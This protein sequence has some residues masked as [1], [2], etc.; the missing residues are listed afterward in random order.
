MP[1]SKLSVRDE[2]K[3]FVLLAAILV[4][5]AVNRLL[6]G[7]LAHLSWIANIG[8]FAVMYTVMAFVEISDVAVAFRKVK[9]TVLALVT[10]FV[11]TPLFAWV[12]GWLVLRPYPDLWAGVILYT[13]TPC[14]GWYLIFTDLAHG[15]VPWGVSLLPWN[16]VLQILLLPLYLWL[17]VGKVVPTSAGTLFASVALYLLA[18]FALGYVVRETLVKTRGR[19]WAYGAYK[20]FIGEVKMWALALL[21]VAIFAFQ[22][23]FGN[24]ALARIGLIIAVISL[25][26]V[27]LFILSL[28]VG[29]LFHLGYADT[30]TLVFTTTARNSESV[31]GVAAVAFAGHPLVL[32]AILIGPVIELPALLG[33]TRLMLWLRTRL[34]WP[35]PDEDAASLR[36]S[37]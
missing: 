35:E 11:F 31:I 5:I 14:I 15:D 21:V 17:L 13:L 7:Q 26:F 4:G 10:N 9:P 19:R 24:L 28:A 12:L 30:T 37:G 6:H 29:R 16:L 33:L 8:L 3:P 27:G 22:P 20:T 1:G 18:P 34:R 2:A 36:T 25:F 23:S 32:M